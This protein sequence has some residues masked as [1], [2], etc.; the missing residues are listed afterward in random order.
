[1]FAVGPSSFLQGYSFYDY[2][3]G[4][5]GFPDT[6]TLSVSL[7][8]LVCTSVSTVYGNEVQ[9]QNF[10]STQAAVN[11][12]FSLA[13]SNVSTVTLEKGAG[14]NIYPEVVLGPRINLATQFPK[15]YSTLATF[16][17]NLQ[18]D[19]NYNIVLD[20]NDTSF[21]WVSSI[22]KFNNFGNGRVVSTRVGTNSNFTTLSQRFWFFAQNDAGTKLI[23]DPNNLPASPSTFQLTVAM[24]YN[25]GVD[26]NPGYSIYIP[27]NYN[28]QFTFWPTPA[29][30]GVAPQP[31]V[32]NF[33]IT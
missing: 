18:V 29:N 33:P 6:S 3:Y 12:P 11:V 22:A 32:P 7:T 9:L 26:Q 25:S 20:K 1:M 23:G 10:V 5:L 13:L 8:R 2:S 19:V 16:N 31:L 14:S 15:V 27:G 28:Y 21:N 17:Y 24:L 4:V 30:Y